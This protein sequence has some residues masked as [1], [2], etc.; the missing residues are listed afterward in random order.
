MGIQSII[1][2]VERV[3]PAAILLL[4]SHIL[5]KGIY[6]P[7]DAYKEQSNENRKRTLPHKRVIEG[8]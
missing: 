2:T 7:N 1:I 3:T 8:G 5:N 6:A 4:L